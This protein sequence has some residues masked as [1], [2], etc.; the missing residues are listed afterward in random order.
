MKKTFASCK[1][2]QTAKLL[3]KCDD[4]TVKLIGA[5]FE[6]IIYYKSK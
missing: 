4:M 2:I 5:F 1:M 3:V 6:I